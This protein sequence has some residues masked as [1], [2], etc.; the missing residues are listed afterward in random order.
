MPGMRICGLLLTLSATGC[1]VPRSMTL[2]Q[3]AAPVGRGA[4]ELSTFVGVA[5][6][7][8]TNPS[9][10]TTDIGGAPLTNQSTSRGFA[11][12]SAEANFQHGFSDHIAL[13]VH[14]SPAGLQPGLKWTLNRSRIAHV[15][16]L[17]AVAFGYA[18]QGG[19]T[20]FASNNGIQ[21][22]NNPQVTTSLQ[23]LAGLKI[24]FSHR[25]GLYAGIGYDF[26]LNRAVTD[27]ITGTQQAQSRNQVLT[28]LTTHQLSAALG[29][30]VPI[31][32]LH[33]R[34]EIAIALN[35]NISSETTVRLP[36]TDPM[37]ATGGFAFAI[38]PGFSLAIA[39]PKK[40]AEEIDEENAQEDKMFGQSTDDEEDK[41]KR[42]QN[43]T[44]D[45]DDD[46]DT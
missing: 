4:N 3:M 2:G 21:V 19:A 33:L 26:S 43:K 5:Y 46:D 23:F 36:P 31:G 7:T 12:P 32:L 20:F 40:S 27:T 28:V 39:T 1:V 29:F 24:L 45:A 44:E 9:F 22:E 18:S 15:A 30:D 14:A 42:R 10:T 37:R 35:P 17:P 41:P 8:Q 11:L 6:A 13:N 16:L 25:S 34:P 38:F